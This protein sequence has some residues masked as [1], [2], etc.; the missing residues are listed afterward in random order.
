MGRC[1]IQFPVEKTVTPRSVLRRGCRT[2]PAER[3]MV[4]CGTLD[5]M[6]HMEE[7]EIRQQ[8]RFDR[9]TCFR[10]TP[11]TEHESLYQGSNVRKGVFAS[12]QHIVHTSS[13]SSIINT[14]HLYFNNNIYAHRESKVLAVAKHRELFYRSSICPP[15]DIG[16]CRLSGST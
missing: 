7:R 3:R 6:L 10:L 13:S 11:F 15:W 9:F 1:A 16:S 2:T 12:W 8:N 4:L 14:S 5:T